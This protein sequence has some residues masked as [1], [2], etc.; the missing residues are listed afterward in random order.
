[1]RGPREIAIAALLSGLTICN[2][3]CAAA[4]EPAD[5]LIRNGTIYIGTDEPEFR[6][7]VVITG[8]HI[9]YVGPHGNNRFDARV[10][11][12]ATA[13][14]VAPGFTTL[15]MSSYWIRPAMRRKPTMCIRK[16]YRTA[17]RNCGSTRRQLCELNRRALA[18]FSMNWPI[19]GLDGLYAAEA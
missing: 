10:V 15:R 1:M 12:D 6:G 13:K 4:K 19:A 2:V 18:H 5:Y 8:D 9:V 11:I 7:N 17:S 3:A 14:I 16:Y